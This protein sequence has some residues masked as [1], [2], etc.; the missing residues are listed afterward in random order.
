MFRKT[1]AIYFR[2]EGKRDGTISEES[3]KRHTRTTKCVIFDVKPTDDDDDHDVIRRRHRR[4]DL[5]LLSCGP[6]ALA[7]GREDRWRAAAAAL[8][9]TG[10][11]SVGPKPS[12]GQVR[13]TTQ[14]RQSR[15]HANRLLYFAGGR[16]TC[17]VRATRSSAVRISIV[18]RTARPRHAVCVCVCVCG[19]ECM[20]AYF[21]CKNVLQY[22]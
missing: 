22:A 1:A 4:R 10:A 9:A 2:G 17:P 15:Q 8:F 7:A 3:A 14:R 13:H 5:G 20:Y 16:R 11:R 6:A 12:G 18:F 21:N 19:H